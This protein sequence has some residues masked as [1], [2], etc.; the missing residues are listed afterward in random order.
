MITNPTRVFGVE[1]PNPFPSSL[2]RK[3]VYKYDPEDKTQ[4]M[5]ERWKQITDI[6]KT[7]HTFKELMDL[8]PDYIEGIYVLNYTNLQPKGKPYRPLQD[9]L[10]NGNA[11]SINYKYIETNID[12]TFDTLQEA[13]ENNHYIKNVC[14]I[15][16]IVDFYCNSLMAENKRK[17]VTREIILQDIGKT[18]YN[19]KDGV[20]V[21]DIIPLFK[22]YNLQLRV[23]DIFCN[24][25]YKYNPQHPNY[26][27]KVCYCMVKGDH[28]YTLNH[29]LKSLS[30]KQ[31]SEVK[32]AIKA[33]ANY[34]INE[35]KTP[36]QYKMIETVDDVVKIIIEIKGK[37][38]S[39]S[40]ISKLTPQASLEEEHKEIKVKGKRAA[41][42][43][44]EMELRAKIESGEIKL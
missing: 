44:K 28:V 9:N 23:F 14:W 22:K 11:V 13:I 17:R 26:H 20:S 36:V 18:E 34:R 24:S 29:D 43:E 1:A 6:L 37:E 40:N 10:K 41:Q 2:Y 31:D 8:K 3:Y 38:P 21:K 16:T 35:S 39:K 7:D 32:I 12:L 5:T 27:N 30:Q 4:T 25:I 15:N 19:I 42:R 33:S